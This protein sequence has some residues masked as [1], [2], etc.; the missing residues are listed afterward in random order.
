MRIDFTPLAHGPSNF[1]DGLEFFE[2]LRL[3]ADGYEQRAMVPNDWNH[4][5]AEETIAIL[6]SNVP[7]F[8]R[9]YGKWAVVTLMD[10]RLR[11]AMM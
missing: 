5:L 2:D 9:P 11:K 8:L 1:K 6:L 10:D 4:K 7:K 3:W